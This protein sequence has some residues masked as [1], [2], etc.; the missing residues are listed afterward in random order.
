MGI[1]KLIQPFRQTYLYAQ[2]VNY[3]QWYIIN[4]PGPY[5]AFEKGCKFASQVCTQ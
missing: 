3:K 2:F 1:S 5:E 4:K